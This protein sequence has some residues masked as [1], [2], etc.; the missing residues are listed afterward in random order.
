MYIQIKKK[1]VHCSVKNQII[2]EI[3][4][5]PF[6]THYNKVLC[7]R[8]GLSKEDSKDLFQ[9][10][11][12][13]LLEMDEDKFLKISNE[14]LKGYVCRILWL[15][16]TSKTAPFRFNNSS[17]TV[18]LN[19]SHSNIAEEESEEKEFIIKIAKDFFKKEDIE[20]KKKG[21]KAWNVEVLKLY[22]D[23]GSYRKVA[24]ELKINYQTVRHIV[25]DLIERINEDISYHRQS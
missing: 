17:N 5:N 14:N 21:Q 7:A 19:D 24:K 4:L 9:S 22:A 2:A 8:N 16:A 25:L 1:L 10:V 12:I 23:L 6:Y 11:I 3:A 13:G 15:N 18:E 20:Y